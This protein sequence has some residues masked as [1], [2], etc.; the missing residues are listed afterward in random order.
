[1]THLNDI[2]TDTNVSTRSK[3]SHLTIDD[4]VKISVLKEL[5]YSRIIHQDRQKPAETAS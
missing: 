4:R 3:G 1:M 5:E 2:T